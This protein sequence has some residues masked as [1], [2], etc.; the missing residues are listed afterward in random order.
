MLTVEQQALAR[1]H[2]ALV[3][4][5]FGT[6]GTPRFLDDRMREYADQP[7]RLRREIG[8]LARETMGMPYPER[9]AGSETNRR[10]ALGVGTAPPEAEEALHAASTNLLAIGGLMSMVPGGYAPPARE[11]DVPV[12]MLYGDHDLHDDRHTREK[13][14]RAPL[15]TTFGLEDAWHCHFVA[16]TR[17]TIWREVDGW[18]R[19]LSA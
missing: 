19:D 6:H 4:F 3:L 12:F 5:S 1:P 15:V 10:A 17:E 8:G 2:A 7:E 18:I 14:P 13:L 9:A 16:N 11:V